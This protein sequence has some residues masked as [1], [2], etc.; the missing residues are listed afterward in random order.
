MSVRT[1]HNYTLQ[2]TGRT[3][4]RISFSPSET[5]NSKPGTKAPSAAV[6]V[7]TN[8]LEAVKAFIEAL[9][10]IRATEP[11]AEPRYP[12]VAKG[13]PASS[14]PSGGDAVFKFTSERL[15]RERRELASNRTME[16]TLFVIVGPDGVFVGGVTRPVA[17]Q[18][19]RAP[20]SPRPTLASGPRETARE[21]AAPQPRHRSLE[22]L[23]SGAGSEASGIPRSG[24][25]A[26]GAP[27]TAIPAR[28]TES[29]VSEAPEHPAAAEPLAEARNDTSESEQPA[30][31]RACDAHPAEQ[32]A[33]VETPAAA[34]Q[35]RYE[36]YETA[37]NSRP[38]DE[39]VAP[40][41]PAPVGIEHQPQVL[42]QYATALG[43]LPANV[44][45][46]EARKAELNQRIGLYRRAQQDNAYHAQASLREARRSAEEAELLRAE[47]ERRQDNTKAQ[48]LRDDAQRFHVAAEHLKAEAERHRVAAEDYERKIVDVQDQLDMVG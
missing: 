12:A 37:L 34:P 2:Q 5:T 30:Q 28:P 27:Q 26:F 31:E 15:T 9:F 39:T 25:R 16:T 10:G 32:P 38:A 3:T 14:P 22:R 40:A 24:P 44:S 47:A 7:R 48:V 42:D 29:L 45:A 21:E 6:V 46:A 20:K 4:A 8:A 43:V 13:E 18:A 35:Y 41:A 17:P 33:P 23:P 1:S 36:A 11:S 19:V